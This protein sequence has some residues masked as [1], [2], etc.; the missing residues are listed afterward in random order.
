MGDLKGVLEHVLTVAGAVLEPSQ[1]L[2]QLGM[3]VVDAQLEGSGLA[4]A[5]DDGVDLLLGLLDHLFD[6]GGMDPAVDDELFKG[7][8]CDLSSDG[9]EA[10]EDDRLGGIVYDQVYA[11]S[12]LDGPDIAAL[13]ADDA[14]L[15]LV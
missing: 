5:L 13:A 15:H 4:F 7:D 3:Q 14:A 12:G 10:R 9:V 8:P 2:D 1:E 11:G 6:A